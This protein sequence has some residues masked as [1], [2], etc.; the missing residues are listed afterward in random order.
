MPRATLTGA[1]RREEL[2]L[3]FSLLDAS[4]F[5]VSYYWALTP[6]SDPAMLKAV[7][8]E[9]AT[10]KDIVWCNPKHADHELTNKVHDEMRWVVDSPNPAPFW[11]KLD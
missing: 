8:E 6:P 4:L 5:R 10:H 2:R 3:S 1:L 7:L 11:V 9:N